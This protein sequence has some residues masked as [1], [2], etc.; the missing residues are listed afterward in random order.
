MK[1]NNKHN[2]RKSK[3]AKPTELA[4]SIRINSS[5]KKENNRV[6]YLLLRK[7][8]RNTVVTIICIY[9][10]A[11]LVLALLVELEMKLCNLLL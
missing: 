8:A 2:Y 10:R 5:S 11:I 3:G 6:D 9:H 1:Q 7:M 4:T